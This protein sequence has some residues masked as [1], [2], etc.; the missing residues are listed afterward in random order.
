M[1]DFSA[2]IITGQEVQLSKFKG[3]VCLVVNVASA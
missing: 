3:K 2:K 1:Y